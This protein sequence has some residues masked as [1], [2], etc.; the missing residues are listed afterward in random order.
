[1]PQPS[2]F[3]RVLSSPDF[4]RL[5][6]STEPLKHLE[7]SLVSLTSK[8]PVILIF[9]I[10]I[11]FD[12]ILFVVLYTDID[13]ISAWFV[14][15][16]LFYPLFSTCVYTSR[17]NFL[18]ECRLFF[19]FTG[20]FSYCLIFQTRIINFRKFRRPIGIVIR[21]V[22]RLN[23]YPLIGLFFSVYSVDL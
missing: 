6:K 16:L 9:G 19:S 21:S 5:H 1:M 8:E 12:I 23:L 13:I 10:D 3:F 20:H 17:R 2:K 22:K 15:N 14:W 11:I 18:W 4:Q 7:Y